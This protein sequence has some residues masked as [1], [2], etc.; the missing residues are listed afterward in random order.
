MGI[1]ANTS[2]YLAGPVEFSPD[3]AEWRI[4]VAQELSGM[5]VVVLNPL[6][7]P[8]WVG[9]RGLRPQPDI[10]AN[11]FVKQGIPQVSNNFAG[12][13]PTEPIRPEQVLVRPD[14]ELALQDM[15]IQRDICLRMVY[16]TN[17]CICRLPKI[18]TVGTFEELTLL[19]K[20]GAPV[21][22]VCPDGIPSMWLVSMFVD[23]AIDIDD[24]FFQDEA[25]LLTAVRHI[26]Q[27]ERQIDPRKW[28][29]L[30]WTPQKGKK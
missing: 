16:A 22:F 11:F 28:I 27:G 7:K 24:V 21:M 25:Q 15:H 26:N 5:G 19:S 8:E 6:V 10:N 29:F 18:F 30:T 1:L 2:C 20:A 13:I 17:W 14:M 4:R 12:Q 9:P 23:K 3:A